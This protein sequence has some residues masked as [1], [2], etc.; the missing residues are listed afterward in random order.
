[1]VYLLSDLAKISVGDLYPV[2]SDLSIGAMLS[3]IKFIR[4]EATQSYEGKLSEEKFNQY[5]DDIGQVKY[6]FTNLINIFV[7]FM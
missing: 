1:M 5:W 4:N 6:Q 2:Q 3:R 7:S